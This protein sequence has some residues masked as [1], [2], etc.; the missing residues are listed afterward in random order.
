MNGLEH[1]EKAEA[2]LRLIADAKTL[3]GKQ[4]LATIALAEAALAIAAALKVGDR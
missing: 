1:Y 4:V 3:E 2:S